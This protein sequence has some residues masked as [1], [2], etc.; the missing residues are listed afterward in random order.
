[1]ARHEKKIIRII[2]KATGEVI[3]SEEIYAEFVRDFS[4]IMD[5]FLV[6]NEFTKP[7]SEE[8]FLWWLDRQGY[9]PQYDKKLEAQKS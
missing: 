7:G 6:N 4:K 3:D 1:M 5:D 8:M 2:Y 9:E